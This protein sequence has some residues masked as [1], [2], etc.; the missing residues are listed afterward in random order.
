MKQLRRAVVMDA[1]EICWW[2]VCAVRL[3]GCVARRKQM[4][5]TQHPDGAHHTDRKG[6]RGLSSASTLA[7]C[8]K[9]AHLRAP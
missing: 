8:A 6:K 3:D 9:T 1:Y 7:F 5:E 4:V 2:L